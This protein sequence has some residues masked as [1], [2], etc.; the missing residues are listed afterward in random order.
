MDYAEAVSAFEDDLASA[1]NRAERNG[2]TD[3][4]IVAELRRFADV[5]EEDAMS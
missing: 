1:S 3:A 5:L 4:E 2:L